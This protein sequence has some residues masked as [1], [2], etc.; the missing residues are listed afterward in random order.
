MAIVLNTKSYAFAGFNTNQQSVYRET[1]AAYPSGFSY[2]T[3]KVNV[4]T[5]T[6][7]SN[8]KWN[9]SI[10]H[11]ATASTACSCEGSVLGTDYVRVESE[12]SPST[13]AADRLDAWTR[14]RDLVASPEFKATMTGLTQPSA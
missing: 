5:G 14:L 6:R 10:P 8:S 12:F 3:S 13:S 7:A 2:L 9:L 4:G 11:V 1:G